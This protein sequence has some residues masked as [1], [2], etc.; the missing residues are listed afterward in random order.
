[1][2]S[3]SRR[4]HAARKSLTIASFD[5][6]TAA[7]VMTA[8]Y[9]DTPIGRSGADGGPVVVVEVRSE[10]SHRGI[11]IEHTET[12]ADLRV[13]DRG[14]EGGGGGAVER[15]VVVCGGH[16]LTERVHHAVEPLTKPPGVVLF[17]HAGPLP[18]MWNP[19]ITF[20]P[21]RPPEAR[22]HGTAVGGLS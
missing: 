5:V 8:R 1:M 14:A 4:S 18:S 15:L 7:S 17:D 19:A 3:V 12:G 9:F 2:Y 6:V 21:T 16:G 20:K 13:G 11:P 22:I 10:Q